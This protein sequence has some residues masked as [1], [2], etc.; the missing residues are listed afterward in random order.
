MGSGV[1]I[2][3]KANSGNISTALRESLAGYVPL[4]DIMSFLFHSL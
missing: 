2:K 1:D 4:E 3:D